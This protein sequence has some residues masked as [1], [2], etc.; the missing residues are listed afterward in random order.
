MS[1]PARTRVALFA[2]GGTIAHGPR[3][4]KLGAQDLVAGIEANLARDGIEVEGADLDRVPS[5]SLTPEDVLEMLRRAQG[6]LDNCRGVVI[7][8][9]TDTLEETGFLFSLHWESDAPLVLTG[10]M[11]PA[12]TSGEDGPR[13]LSAACRVA[14]DPLSRGRGPLVVMHDKIFRA[15]DVTKVHSWDTD[16]FA[17]DAGAEGSIDPWSN[18]TYH[19]PADGP[20]TLPRKPPEYPEPVA[21]LTVGAGSDG[22]EVDALVSAGYRGLVLA[23][24]GRGGIPGG[25]KDALL[26]AI[27]ADTVVVAASRCPLGGTTAGY[28]SHGILWAGA[29]NAP[30]ARLLL[31][32]GLALWGRDSE[33]LA[34]IF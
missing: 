12:R 2:T 23:V 32:T 15:G 16:T 24:A 3:G 17:A 22:S 9:G 8:H 26:R 5:S 19:R 7:T 30:K 29:L 1:N 21:I 11:R 34:Q 18:L 4:I 14:A 33:K 25:T 27:S 6:V 13:N 28:D 20:K 10:A 31:M